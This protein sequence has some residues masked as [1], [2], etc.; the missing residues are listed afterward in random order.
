MIAPTAP[1][2]LDVKGLTVTY[3]GVAAVKGVDFFVRVGEVVAMI[4]ANGAGKSSTLMALSGV[5]KSGGSVTFATEEIRHLSAPDRVRCGLVQVPEGRRIFG[6]NTVR[7][8][9]I[10]GAFLRR[11]RSAIDDDITQ[12]LDLFPILKVRFHQP[13]GNLSGGE[14]QM[15]AIGRGLMARPKMLLLDEPSLGL[16]PKFADT[17]FYVI[18]QLANEGRSIL[19]VEQNA[20]AALQISERAYCLESGSLFLSGQ[21]KELAQNSRIREAYLGG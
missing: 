2:L 12:V 14:Q 10:L 19:L 17:I 1:I 15:L 5:I 7:E 6:H 18:R 8:N 11:D 13:A 3:G 16:S 21:S 4:G 20:F 9:L